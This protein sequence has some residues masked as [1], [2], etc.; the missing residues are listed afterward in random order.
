MECISD[1]PIFHTFLLLK[2][3]LILGECHD[4]KVLSLK[5]SYTPEF[6]SSTGF[7]HLFFI[8]FFKMSTMWPWLW[9]TYLEDI[10]HFSFSSISRSAGIQNSSFLISGEWV[11]GEVKVVLLANLWYVQ[12]VFMRQKTERG[13]VRGNGVRKPKDIGR[14]EEK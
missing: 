2:L 13:F 6:Y 14:K 7:L 9:D 5:P 4:M 1:A 11:P 12:F 10:A 3:Q 8:P